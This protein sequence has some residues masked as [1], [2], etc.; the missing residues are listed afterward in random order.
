MI[1]ILFICHGNICRSS[2]A[3]AVMRD[4]IEN[5]DLAGCVT[6][7]SAATSTEE[8]GN[9]IYPPAR[10]E[11]A[12][13]GLSNEAHRARRMTAKDYEDHD[14]LIGMDDENMREISR[15]C[16]A[17]ELC[18][19][20]DDPSRKIRRLLD[21]TDDRKHQDISDPWYTRDFTTCYA[22]IEEGCKGL[23]V[24]LRNIIIQ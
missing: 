19:R 9:H 2:M 1:R 24:T 12:K 8:I 4:M 14:L 3:E 6:V 11:L 18:R 22:D 5:S 17:D 13:H 20:G 23:M 16:R 7:D 21:F 15:I 10:A